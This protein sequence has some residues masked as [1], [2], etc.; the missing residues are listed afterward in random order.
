MD[1]Q[2]GDIGDC[3]DSSILKSPELKPPEQ[4]CP[5]DDSVV[6]TGS[7][8]PMPQRRR[9]FQAAAEEES[10]LAHAILTWCWEQYD[11]AEPF[12]VFFDPGKIS[13]PRSFRKL[14]E[15]HLLNLVAFRA[16]YFLLFLINLAFNVT[17][18][19]MLVLAVTAVVLV[20]A[21]LKL[22]EEGNK[23]TFWDTETTM[24]G[25]KNLRLLVAVVLALPLLYIGYMWT[26]VMWS[27]DTTTAIIFVHASLHA[28]P[29]VAAELEKKL[30]V[31]PQEVDVPSS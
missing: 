21:V 17:D 30:E 19:T 28:G 10:D 22:H 14:A 4:E 25:G 6:A 20:R 13:P 7:P 8:T 16:N 23:A 1:R 18:D 5:E 24:P 27:I 31:V 15:R 26:A 3:F 2:Q 29:G 11:H 12:S 9:L